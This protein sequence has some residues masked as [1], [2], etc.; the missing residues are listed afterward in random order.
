MSLLIGKHIYKVLSDDADIK[1]IVGDKIFPIVV[2]EGTLFPFIAFDGISVTGIYTKDGCIGDTTQLTINCIGQDFDTV[3]TLAE[4]VRLV[5]EQQSAEYGNYSIG[6]GELMGGGFD[7]DGQA[8]IA[9]LNFQ[10]ETNY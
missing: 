7:Y 2:Q 5:L 8:F 9:F 4:N 10:F 1:A 3:A 6:S